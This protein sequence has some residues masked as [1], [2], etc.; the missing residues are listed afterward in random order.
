MA[1][2]LLTGSWADS[3]EL[4]LLLDE[5]FVD[6]LAHAPHPLTRTITTTPESCCCGIPI[7]PGRHTAAALCN[8]D[9][10]IAHH[11]HR[12]SIACLVFA[13]LAQ[14]VAGQDLVRDPGQEH[15]SF[16]TSI[17]RP[18]MIGQARD[19]VDAATGYLEPIKN[20]VWPCQVTASD[21]RFA[22]ADWP[23]DAPPDPT[24]EFPVRFA[25]EHL[26]PHDVGF[27]TR[28]WNVQRPLCGSVTR[29]HFVT[30]FQPPDPLASVASFAPNETLYDLSGLPQDS[31]DTVELKPPSYNGWRATV[32]GGIS[33]HGASKFL[34]ILRGKSERGTSEIAGFRVS[35]V[36]CEDWQGLPIDWLVEGGMVYHI[37]HNHHNRYSFFG[38]L[39]ADL[40][41]SDLAGT[42]PWSPFTYVR[43]TLMATEGLSYATDIPVDE[44][45]SLIGEDQSRLLIAL[46]VGLNFNGRDLCNLFL[47]EASELGRDSVWERLNLQV[48][49]YHRSGAFGLFGGVD[50]G[51]N[52]PNIGVEI[53]F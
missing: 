42:S 27:N 19:M 9:A 20:A 38:G 49:V 1:R 12:F 5:R 4:R 2:D 45:D 33:A 3:A 50:G 26:A 23:R 29:R 53:R 48:N 31:D 52:Y 22:P 24:A 44:A 21:T 17:S 39:R 37:E 30:P 6:H 46:F 11:D 14:A 8:G 13:T 32:F 16:S 18:L 47:S 10:L 41:L 15:V 35:R 51:S 43:T 36:I 25:F 34:E 28:G 7:Q 40:R